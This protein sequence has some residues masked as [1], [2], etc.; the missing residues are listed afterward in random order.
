[1]QLTNS[2]TKVFANLSETFKRDPENE[3]PRYKDPGIRARDDPQMFEN[4][5]GS[6]TGKSGQSTTEARQGL[7][8]SLTFG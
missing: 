8:K 3:R 5:E 4:I 6:R 2:L 7:I 1:M